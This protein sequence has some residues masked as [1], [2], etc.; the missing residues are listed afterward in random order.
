MASSNP[1]FHIPYHEPYFDEREERALLECVRGGYVQGDGKFTK[2]VEA[3]LRQRLGVKHAI[4]TTS[5]T[6]ALE[7]AMMVLDVK[8]GD[9]VIVPSYTFASTATCVTRQF[10]DVVFCDVRQDNLN[11]DVKDFERRITPKTRAVIPVHYAGIPADMDEVMAVAKARGLDVVEDAAQSLDTL[12]KG[13]MTGTIGR[14]GCLSFHGTKNLAAGEGGALLTN[15]GALAK[16]AEVLREKGTDRAQFLRGEIDKYTWRDTGTSFVPSELV[17]A[18]LWAQLGKIDEIQ[19]KRIAIFDRY[20]E[21]TAPLEKLGLVS[22]PYVPPGSRVNAHIFYL[23]G[24]D[25][26][27]RDKIFD[28][29]RARGIQ[30]M[31]HYYPLD[32]SPY[33][34]KFRKAG[35]KP[36]TGAKSVTD[37]M[38]RLPSFTRM[39]DEQVEEVLVNLYELLGVARSEVPPRFSDVSRR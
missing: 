19:T 33:G 26:A 6:H 1:T 12:Y 5:G 37:R 20:L 23:L 24:K 4:A 28:G 18:L 38:V 35:D 25:A 2:A 32:S 36:L 27:T 11:I 13:T 31:L 3:M 30:A 21:A 39:T 9:E 15:D 29:L 14:L 16:R 7:L 22:R 34:Q 8:A 17:M 10:A